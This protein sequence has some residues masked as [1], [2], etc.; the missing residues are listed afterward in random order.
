MTYIVYG[1]SDCPAC[2]RAC[3]L[4]MDKD[5]EYAFVNTDFSPAYRQHVKETFNWKTMPVIVEW[6]GIDQQ[7]I[8]GYDQLLA[9]LS[10]G[11]KEGDE[12]PKT[13]T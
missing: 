4:L 10:W 12:K 2:L 6:S 7:L 8:G 11:P 5:K 13:S 9:Q 1:I 3:A